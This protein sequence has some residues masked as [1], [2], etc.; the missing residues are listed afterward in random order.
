M[1]NSNQNK[2]TE[3]NGFMLRPVFP[4]DKIEFHKQQMIGKTEEDRL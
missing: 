3:N 2:K 4:E 1:G